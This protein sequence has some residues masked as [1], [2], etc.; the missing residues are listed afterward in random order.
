[1]SPTPTTAQRRQQAVEIVGKL[2]KH[3]RIELQGIG[4]E[5]QRERIQQTLPLLVPFGHEQYFGLLPILDWDHH[6]P[7][8][9]AVLRIYAYYAEETLRAGEAEMKARARVIQLRDRFPD[10]PA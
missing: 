6:L 3:P 1:L 2:R 10:S 8:T 9:N 5:E 7:T 4:N